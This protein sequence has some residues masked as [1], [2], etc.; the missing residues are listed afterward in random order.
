[1]LKNFFHCQKNLSGQFHMHFRVLTAV[2]KNYPSSKKK[3][4]R[5]DVPP[6]CAIE[7]AYLI[8]L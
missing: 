6:G 7:T 5:L 1:M 2:A 3:D 8:L 4:N